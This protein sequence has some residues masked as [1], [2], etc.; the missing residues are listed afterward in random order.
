MIQ[1]LL[2]FALL[3]T[4]P[5][6]RDPTPVDFD[7]R[8]R[9]ILADRCFPCH[10]PDGEAREADLRLDSLGGITEDLGGYQAVVPGDPDASEMILRIESAVAR[11]RMPPKKSKLSLSPEEIE[12]LRRWVAEG[13]DY[14]THWALARPSRHAPPEVRDP[15][16]CLDPLDRFVLARLE[17]QGLD[18]AVEAEWPDLLRRAS[19]VVTGL[20]PSEQQ[21]DR[22]GAEPSPA[23]YASWIDEL[24]ASPA[25][26]EHMASRWLD[27]ARYADSYGYQ[28]DASRRVWPY[29]DWV[30]RAYNDNL[31]YD[32]FVRQQLAGDL[33]PDATR[34]TRLATAFNRLHRQTNEGGSIEEE[35]RQEY[36]ADRV[37]TFGSVF[38]GLT[39]ECARCHDHKFDPIEQREYFALSA[40]FDNIDESGLYS[41]FTPATPT[42][43]LPLPEPEQEQALQ[44]AEQDVS[45]L[46]EELSRALREASAEPES[47]LTVA[48]EDR[49]PGE[50]GRYEFDERGEGGF[51]NEFDPG[52]PASVDPGVEL[53]DGIEGLAARLDGDGGVRFPGVGEHRRS[54][55]F[56]VSFWLRVPRAYPRAI[57][58]H[59]SRAWT[60]AGSQGWQLLIEEGRLTA[61]LIHFWPGDA[62]A[63]RT[64]D[65]LPVD[66]WFHLAFCYDGSSRAAGLEL[67]L[68]GN[69]CDLEVIRDRL[70]HSITGG[71]PG[72]PTLGQRF[73]DLGLA[74]GMVD[75]L[76]FFER[77]LVAPEVRR[78][79][80]RDE[81]RPADLVDWRSEFDPRVASVRFELEEARRRRDE[82]RDQ[83]P[84]IMVMEEMERPRQTRMLER[85]RYDAPREVLE[86]AT[87]AAV[88]APD[89]E[90]PGER[91]RDR[92]G[93]ADWLLDPRHPLT[94]RVEANR[95]WE[96]VFGRGLVRTTENFGRQGEPPS[97]PR[98]L[99]RLALD[100]IESG[101]D[102]RALLRR[103]LLSATFR[104]T[105]V[106]DPARRQS[107]L[108]NLLWSRGPS[109]RLTAEMVRD[110][111]LFVSGLLT[112]RIGGPSVRPY[113]PPGLWEEK[114]GTS[115]VRSEGEDLYRRS[116]YTFWKRTS[117]PPAMMVFDAAKRDVC[118]ARRQQTN[119]PLQALV[120]WND[121]QLVEACR[122]LA[123]GFAAGSSSGPEDS[124]GRTDGEQLDRLFRKLTSRRPTDPE[125]AAL[126]EL[127][128]AQR[129]AGAL[130]P[131]AVEAFRS[132]GEAP[133]PADLDPVDHAAWTLVCSALFCADP[134]VML[135]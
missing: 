59:R 96:V 61:A 99:D 1:S 68:D 80:G 87:P 25:H 73:R 22:I 79:A 131:A 8:I 29:R 81:P 119:T 27:L 107:D 94:A 114:S 11:E 51:A 5:P 26:G 62:A 123:A 14:P 124:A 18:A 16:W 57:V 82:I 135:R 56:S 105:S 24:L 71:G 54:E 125:R 36:V 31:P 126:L 84:T 95:L 76:R 115:Y 133:V 97:H 128:A 127:L 21:L 132:V 63:V 55:P 72:A 2:V 37:N 90:R 113:Q 83:I 53:V 17:E 60:D 4:D 120:L 44:Q 23:G 65:A 46:E 70:R 20:P 67:F 7:A 41:H 85:G 122:V 34:D 88:R 106:A 30:I 52:H 101:W 32:R 47:G 39:L 102:R 98:L 121:P 134:V 38:L 75:R 10:G 129:K 117:P 15:D 6:A 118:Q 33:L 40:Y 112:D 49:W 12:L 9:P 69:R 13:A 108:G 50:T 74:G 19:Y 130:D 111:A 45:R 86:P 91:P 100:L 104:Q 92:L 43:A 109:R 116:L 3:L 110:T 35:F 58:L 103:M 48:G 28:A 42:P 77:R 89:S 93:L 64:V 78:L 66:R